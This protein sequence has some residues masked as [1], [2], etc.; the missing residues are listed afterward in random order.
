VF[1]N[2]A[3]SYLTKA[4]EVGLNYHMKCEQYAHSAAR[5][6]FNFNGTA[7]E[8]VSAAGPW[9]GLEFGKWSL[10]VGGSRRVPA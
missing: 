2:P 10:G 3:E 1:T 5:S 6:F 7:G 4:Q 8:C 9:A